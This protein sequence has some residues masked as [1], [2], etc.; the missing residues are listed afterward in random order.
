MLGAPVKV[1][2]EATLLQVPYK[3]LPMPDDVAIKVENLTKAYKLYNSPKDRLKEALSPIRRKYHHDFHALYNVNFEVKKG[4]TVGI[5]GKNG[6]GKSTLLKI[7]TGVLTSTSGRVTV[8]GRISALLELGAGFNPELTGLENVYFNGTLMGYSQKQIENRLDAILEFADIGD[9]VYQPVKSYSSGMF[10][11]L[12]FAV[13][14]S[15]EP[16]IL[17]IDEA[18]AVGDMFFQAK[19]MSTID[20]FRRNG[21]SILIVTHD[22]NAI[23]S[24]CDRAVLLKHGNVQ[25]F[26]RS[27]EVADR[28]VRETREE[29]LAALGQDVFVKDG[30]NDSTGLNLRAATTQGAIGQLFMESNAFVQRVAAFRYGTGE[31]R[32]VNA[33]L[34]DSQGNVANCVE[35]NETI[36]IRIHLVCR[37]ECVVSVNYLIRDDKGINI[38][39]SNFRIEEV[40]LIEAKNGEKYVVEYTTKTPIAEGNYNVMLSITEPVVLNRAAK[41][42]DVVENAIVFRVAERPIAKLWA[43]V[44][45]ENEVKVER[46][47][48]AIA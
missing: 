42:I 29:S 15:T 38:I 17:I 3:V 6:S 14:I 16:E 19:C 27:V 8:N 13:A 32:V 33:E 41:S 40:H 11:R 1:A 25:H 37:S 48:E 44:Y 36:T 5:I 9:F 46:Y 24:L 31:A 18:L 47:N 7:I 2:Y 30:N 20:R 26:G 35:Y 43:K 28:Y 4:E 22:T 23:K 39:G 45:I 12:A 34:L 21:A 10:V